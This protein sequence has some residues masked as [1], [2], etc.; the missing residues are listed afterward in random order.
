MMTMM[1]AMTII[2]RPPPPTP[3]ITA[4]VSSSNVCPS[5]AATDEGVDVLMTG[6]D[7]DDAFDDDVDVFGEV[8][9]LNVADAALEMVENVIETVHDRFTH[10]RI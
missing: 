2:R 4:I 9:P 10:K 1:N 8:V 3:A 6:D 5:P 7:V